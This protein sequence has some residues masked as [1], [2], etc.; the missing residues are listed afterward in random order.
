[1]SNETTPP[2][3]SPEPP[4]SESVKFY[5][6]LQ[7][8]T[9]YFVSPD[10]LLQKIADYAEA[11]LP[12]KGIPIT[13]YLH[14]G[15]IAGHVSNAQDF[16]RATAEA[17][18]ESVINATDDGELPQWG[19]DFATSVIESVAD[20]VAQ[21]LEASKRAFEEHGTTNANCILGRNLY[22]TNVL[23]TVPGSASI[24]KDFACVK[25]TQVVGW[26]YGVTS[27]G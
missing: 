20:D 16:Y 25:L 15:L 27:W 6:S 13:L 23:Y 7:Q 12:G 19:E 8:T 11:N 17:F 2:A 26:S 3:D 21:E 10:R 18:R 9:D 5:D 14:G 4:V 24:A 1:M 22:L